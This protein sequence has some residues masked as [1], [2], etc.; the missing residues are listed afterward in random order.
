MRRGLVFA[1]AL[2][3][4][5]A[6][7]RI[8]ITADRTTAAATCRAPL[9]ARGTTEGRNDS[10]TMAP[11]V[12]EL[13]IAMIFVDFADAR[14]RA[15]PL[16]IYVSYVPRVVDWYWTVS[17]HRLQIDVVAAQD[18]V[19]LPKPFSYYVPERL[20]E[21]LE[22]GVALAD[23]T[24]DFSGVDALYVIPAAGA[25][26]NGVG[27]QIRERPLDPDGS[28]I[29]AV[30]WLPTDGNG[31]RSVPFVIHETGHMLGL[32]D[33]YLSGYPE[34]YHWWDVMAAAANPA[35]TGGMFAWH[36][37][38]LD[39]LEPAQFVCLAGRGV[40][41]AVVTPVERQ[42]GVKALVYRTK[43]AAY[44]AEVRQRIAE[45][46]GICRTG[47]LMY[48]VKLERTFSKPAIRLLPARSD[49]LS[50]AGGCGRRYNATYGVGRGEV[51]RVSIGSVRFEVRAALRDGSYRIRVSNRR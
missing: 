34:T 33:L 36:R 7:A 30:A 31:A 17:Y 6:A 18:W 39:W 41:E 43:E 37:W 35:T 32:P 20:E 51:S 4:A 15:R 42:G 45:D 27:V 3:L 5:L 25:D 26:F 13:R 14:G 12:G 24:F 38:K 46:A 49:D 16:D 40:R 19:T 44:V 2:L 10:A 8:G 22:T 21:A 28:S 47:V 29:W 50:R 11:W 9:L 48:A 1:A 23:R